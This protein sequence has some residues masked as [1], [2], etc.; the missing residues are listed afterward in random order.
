[1]GWA[2]DTGDG[3]STTLYNPVPLYTPVTLPLAA[4]TKILYIATVK[5]IAPYVTSFNTCDFEIHDIDIVCDLDAGPTRAE[6]F[7]YIQ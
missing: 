4:I 7:D 1:M 2:L 6:I 3:N 5:G